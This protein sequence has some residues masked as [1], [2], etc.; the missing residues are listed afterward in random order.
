MPLSIEG[1]GG[2][3]ENWDGGVLTYFRDLKSPVAALRCGMLA[4][5]VGE[6]GNRDSAMPALMLPSPLQNPRTACAQ[7]LMYS[8]CNN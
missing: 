2:G 4:D 5:V 3:A 8:N 7:S 1:V 6:A